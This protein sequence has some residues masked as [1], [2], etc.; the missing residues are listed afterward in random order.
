MKSK[1]I[2]CDKEINYNPS[3][4][5]GKYCSNKCQGFYE[6]KVKVEAGKS[7]ARTIRQYLIE[8]NIY[9]CVVCGNQ[10]EWQGHPLPLQLD[11]I[12]GNPKNNTLDN[13]RWL[14]PN[15]HCQTDNWGSKNISQDNRRKLVTNGLPT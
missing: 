10:G 2:T 3:Q 1:C 5:T 6:R 12:D 14:C 4:K 15:C 11:H 9:E 8:R 7:T 13:V